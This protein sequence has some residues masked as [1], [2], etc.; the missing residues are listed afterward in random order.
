V[1]TAVRHLAYFGNVTHARLA[2]A[3]HRFRYRLT[4]VGVDLEEAPGFFARRWFWSFGRWNLACILRRDHLRGGA[5]DLATAVRDRVEARTGIRPAGRILLVTQPRYFGHCFNPISF[6]LCHGEDGKLKAVVLEVH[7]TPWGEQCAYVL[8]VRG[9][10]SRF[11]AEFDKEMHVSPFMTMDLRYRFEL[12]RSGDDMIVLLEGIRRGARTFTARLALE[13][14]PLDGPALARLLAG[15][16]FMTLRI[17]VAI[18][19]EA[20][21]LWLK[22]IPFV[23]HP[24]RRASSSSTTP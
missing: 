21:R 1:S 24:G 16:P 11:T 7:N 6:Y 9:G 19:W 17:V 2:P 20:L 8:P 18:H 12:R 14:R 22:R 15:H 4:M 13:A 5:G 3:L 10:G 23:P